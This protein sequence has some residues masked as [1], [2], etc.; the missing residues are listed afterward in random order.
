MPNAEE[1][2]S[3]PRI[4]LCEVLVDALKEALRVN[5]LTDFYRLLA[6][7]LAQVGVK[8]AEEMADSGQT[9]GEAFVRVA[10]DEQKRF[11]ERMKSVRASNSKRWQKW[12][13]K[14]KANAAPTVGKQLANDEQT[15]SKPLANAAPTVGKHA[16]NSLQT[17]S[18]ARTETETDTD[19][20]SSSSSCKPEEPKM[21]TSASD[22]G[23]NMTASFSEFDGTVDYAAIADPWND[24]VAMTLKA[25][26]VNDQRNYNAFA[27][28]H[29][30]LGDRKFRDLLASFVGEI[31]LGECADIDN[32]AALF[33][34]RLQQVS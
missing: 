17:V 13:T 29:K 31:S 24:P 19:T 10:C 34:S 18:R 20:V 27:K 1:R 8:A 12:D 9:I 15:V 16:A 3:A 2:H 11:T 28:Q 23:S 26:H 21:K 4:E 33:T 6:P 30:R 5:S 14:R 25:C 22:S 7:T 32:L